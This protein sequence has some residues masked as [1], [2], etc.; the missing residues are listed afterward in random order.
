MQKKY[1]FFLIL[2]AVL[3]WNV[4]APCEANVRFDSWTTGPVIYPG[5]GGAYDAGSALDPEI[6][7]D[8]DEFRLYYTAVDAAGRH[9]I[10]LALS[11]DAL[12]WRPY[13]I[14]FKGG[15]EGFDAGGVS[16]PAIVRAEEGFRLYYTGHSISETLSV[17]LVESPDG[18]WF[19]RNTGKPRRVLS[20][21]GNPGL[22]D[23]TGASN[24]SVLLRNGVFMMM[25]QGHDGTVWKRLGLAI[26]QDGESFLKIQGDEGKGAVFGLGPHG[27]DDAGA[28]APELWS[29][30]DDVRMFY[31]SL[32]Y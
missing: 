28:L 12:T 25:Y 18:Y 10:A 21:S 13:G 20:G 16:D 30:D 19:S 22:F 24:P 7:W 26:S 29:I 6:Y 3:T 31:T 9:H 23:E 4:K 17:G 2:A 11:P 14:V 5:F 8:G 15:E 1:L 27:F 32:H